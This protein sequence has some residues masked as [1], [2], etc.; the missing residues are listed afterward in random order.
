MRKNNANTT[1]LGR[2]NESVNLCRTT[3]SN[4]EN[5]KESSSIEKI[6][7][8]ENTGLPTKTV[9]PASGYFS[10]DNSSTD[11]LNTEKTF[12]KSENSGSKQAES[13]LLL[14]KK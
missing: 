9:E 8:H 6:S 7:E 10:L 12:C 13:K 4:S 14:W 3:T 11:F 2:E 1:A 5:Y